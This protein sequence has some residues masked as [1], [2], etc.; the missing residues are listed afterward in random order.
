MRTHC[1]GNLVSSGNQVAHEL[2]GTK[3]SILGPK[4]V[5]R[6]LFEQNS[7]YSDRQHH[8]G[9]LHKQGKGHEVVLFCG[10]S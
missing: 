10:G 1:K 7:S 3:S 6:R 9:C 2:P 4:R 5:P 8:F